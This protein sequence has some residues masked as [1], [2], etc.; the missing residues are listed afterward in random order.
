[1]TII[2][3]ALASPAAKLALDEAIEAGERVIASAAA[4]LGDGLDWNDVEEIK[5]DVMREIAIITGRFLKARPAITH[6]AQMLAK[7]IAVRAWEELIARHFNRLW[8]LLWTRL[9]AL[10]RWVPWLKGR[11][12]VF[13]RDRLMRAGP[14]MLEAAVKGAKVAGKILAK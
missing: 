9:P 10:A 14:G 5:V 1:M 11:V 3:N 7:S 12:G 4:R 6:D 2:D 8:D 13:L